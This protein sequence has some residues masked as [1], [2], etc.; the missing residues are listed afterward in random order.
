MRGLFKIGAVVGLMALM[1][2]VGWLVAMTGAG[3]GV[4][5]ASLNDLEREFTERMQGVVLVGHFTIEGLEDQ[6]GNPE[7][8]E[9]A[10][11][12]KVGDG[13]WRFNARL[14]Y[15]GIDV[16]LPVTVPL[17]WAGD[18]PMVSITDFTIPTLGTFTARVFFYE[19]R[20]AGSWQHGEYGG[21]MYGRIES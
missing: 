14:R 4:D 9:I 15:G 6:G 7:R 5:P 12:T 11:V 21:L 20:Y 1:F 17:V 19:E 13:R 2:A 8:Y 16:T 18:T 10:R 3:Q